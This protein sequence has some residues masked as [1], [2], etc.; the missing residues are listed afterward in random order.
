MNYSKKDLII[1]ALFIL[2]FY[3]HFFKKETFTNV[4]LEKDAKGNFVIPGN[5][6]VNGTISYNGTQIQ[7]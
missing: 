4:N 3:L 5:L 2:S 7:K 1:F 6:K